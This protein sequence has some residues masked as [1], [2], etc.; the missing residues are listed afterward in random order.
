M[1]IHR[2]FGSI[3]GEVVELRVGEDKSV[4]LGKIS[5][6]VDCGKAINPLTIEA[7]IE[8]GIIYGLT[9]AMYGQINVEAGSAVQRNFD[10]YEMV[11]LAQVPQIDVHILENGP[12]G[13]IGEPGVPPIA[14]ALT[15]AL[16][17]A[18]GER[19]RKLP[20][21]EAGYTLTDAA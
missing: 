18:T 4:Q 5:A 21:T 9:A 1:A 2:S 6:V 13:G 12:I 19:V 3:V 11:K 8:G 20:L 7:Q 16:F 14:P 10:K 15:N 17:K